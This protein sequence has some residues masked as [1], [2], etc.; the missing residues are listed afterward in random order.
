MAAVTS[1]INQLRIPTYEQGAAFVAAAEALARQ[2]ERQGALRNLEA[3]DI[4]MLHPITLGH[5]AMNSEIEQPEDEVSFA[6]AGQK[7]PYNPQRTHEIQLGRRTFNTVTGLRTLTV[8]RYKAGPATELNAS[9]LTW[10]FQTRKVITQGSTGMARATQRVISPEDPVA[11]A[12][13]SIEQALIPDTDEVQQL[14]AF[15]KRLTADPHE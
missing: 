2:T 12:F 13:R 1:S 14:I 5:M 3:R 11:V 7:W 9:G 4:A 10:D 15:A 6:L 8:S